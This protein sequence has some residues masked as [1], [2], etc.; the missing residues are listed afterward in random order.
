MDGLSSDPR[1][2]PDREAWAKQ[3]NFISAKLARDNGRRKIPPGK[4]ERMI[5]QM[6]H[7]MRLLETISQY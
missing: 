5:V 6:D 1:L 2:G 4:K 3:I 7:L